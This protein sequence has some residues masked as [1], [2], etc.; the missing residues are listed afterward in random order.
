MNYGNFQRLWRLFSQKQKLLAIR[1]F[2]VLVIGMSMEI[3]GI[4]L[5]IPAFTLILQE[6]IL[7]SYPLLLNFLTMFS[8][9][10]R[11]NFVVLGIAL[12]IFIFVLKNIYLAFQYWMQAGFSLRILK[13]F[14]QILN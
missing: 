5:I 7:D 4:A 8:E 10:T 1:L 13:E 11:E 2:F 14:S 3:L 6:D 9:P 12:M